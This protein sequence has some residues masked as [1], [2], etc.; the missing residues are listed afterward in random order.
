MRRRPPRS[1][2]TDTLFPYTTLF[3][4][5]ARRILAPVA[6]AQAY[7][8]EQRIEPEAR[9]DRQYLAEPG[10]V[11]CRHR[12]RLDHRPHRHGFGCV[13]IAAIRA[14]RRS[15]S[16]MLSPSGGGCDSAGTRWPMRSALRSE[17]HTSELQALMRI[18]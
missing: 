18:S 15:G 4:S 6:A 7:P 13:I 9:R 8:R 12:Q 1:T 2:R 16:A 14:A 3:R 17:E 11:A 5:I 10:P